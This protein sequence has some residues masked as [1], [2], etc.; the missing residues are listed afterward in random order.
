MKSGLT[1]YWTYQ[2]LGWGLFIFINVFF[3]FTFDKFTFNLIGRLM[4]F[5]GLGFGFS[6][7]MRSAIIRSNVLLKPLQ[8]QL[9]GFMFITLIF[10]FTIACIQSFL[11]Q[12]FSLR[13]R[14]ENS[15]TE[16]KVLLSNTFYA[17]VY[18]F[19]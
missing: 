1:K 15:F 13:A 9:V 12:L 10:A 2:L 19:M 11:T 14:Q 5:V 16:T 8:Q 17:F 4:I 6:H 3:A 7:L 18:L